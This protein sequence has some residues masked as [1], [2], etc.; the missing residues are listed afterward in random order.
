MAK[1]LKRV[2]E[3]MSHLYS[4]LLYVVVISCTM[5]LVFWSTYLTNKQDIIKLHFHIRNDYCYVKTSDRCMKDVSNIQDSVSF[6]NYSKFKGMDYLGMHLEYDCEISH[7]HADVPV[8]VTGASSNHFKESLE[9]LD[10][11]QNILMKKIYPNREITLIYYDLGLTKTQYEVIRNKCECEVRKFPFRKFPRHFRNL[12][13]FAWKPAIIRRMLYEEDFIM[14]VDSSIRFTEDGQ[15]ERVFRKARLNGVQ[16]MKGEGKIAER[17]SIDTMLYLKQDPE[18]LLTYSEVQGGF[19]I[20][21]RSRFTL[22]VVVNPWVLCAFD[23][24]C[25]W[26][27]SASSLPHDCKKSQP[28]QRYSFCHRSDQSVLGI[29]LTHTMKRKRDQCVTFLLLDAARMHYTNT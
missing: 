10:N 29:I 18:N 6:L 11:I 5:A 2:A 1:I 12:S 27:K 14:W 21:S 16:C 4:E 19:G 15:I 22:E 13:N 28:N 26:P 25:I 8:V 3:E 7:R 17:T 9:V 24:D 23:E 20:Y